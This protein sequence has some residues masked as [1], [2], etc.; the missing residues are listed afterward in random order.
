M[1]IFWYSTIF[2]NF[3]KLNMSHF[4]LKIHHQLVI[5]E[6][7][8]TI[9]MNL[10]VGSETIC[11]V[12]VRVYNLLS[13][14][15]LFQRFKSKKETDQVCTQAK[16][17]KMLFPCLLNAWIWM[18]LAELAHYAIWVGSCAAR[19]CFLLHCQQNICTVFAECGIGA[20]KF[21]F[22]THARVA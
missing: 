11:C 9:S 12:R 15:C 18:V 22:V 13:H 6:F 7:E 19:A 4:I 21:N 3:S 14:A 16:L 17:N 1:H 20:Y 2:V 10:Y 8:R 5:L